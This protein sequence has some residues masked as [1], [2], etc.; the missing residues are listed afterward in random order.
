MEKQL[1]TKHTA[2]MHE[3]NLHLQMLIKILQNVVGP[4]DP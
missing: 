3:M 4:W 2:K 1:Q